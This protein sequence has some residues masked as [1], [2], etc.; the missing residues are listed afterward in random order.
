MNKTI[1]KLQTAGERLWLLANT[2]AQLAA[3]L[4]VEG[5]GLSVVASESR[6]LSYKVQDLVERALFEGGEIIKPG[7]VRDVAMMLNLLALNSAIES[8]RMGWRGKP[9]AVC[10]EDIR[11]LAIDVTVLFDLN[12]ELK[13]NNMIYPFPKDPIT[14]LDERK[15]FLWMNIAGINVVEPL[16]NIKEI[17]M[18]SENCTQTHLKLRGM[19]IPLIDGYKLLGKQKEESAFVILNTPWAEQNK[20]YAVT[21]NVNEIVFC[22]IGKPVEAPSDM[23]LA[24]YVRECWESEND[25]PF[26]F[27]DWRKML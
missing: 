25:E 18:G 27:M 10:A 13:R 20:T 7:N 6:K 8:H 3:T 15:E 26:Y 24:K 4:E 5:R 21:A 19:E 1:W 23:P 9:A 2:T 17:C 16:I 11:Q 22:P 12:D 14:S